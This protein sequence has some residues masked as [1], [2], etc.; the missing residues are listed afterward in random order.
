MLI[1]R[2]QDKQ[3]YQPL[4]YQML[5]ERHMNETEQVVNALKNRFAELQTQS[6]LAPFITLRE[7]DSIVLHIEEM[8]QSAARSLL[9]SGFPPE[10]QQLQGALHQAVRAGRKVFA[11][12]M[13]ESD[14]GLKYQYL[15]HISPMQYRQVE[16]HGRWFALIAVL[17]AGRSGY[18]S[19]KIPTLW[20]SPKMNRHPQVLSKEGNRTGGLLSSAEVVR[21]ALCKGLRAIAITDHD[22][23]AGVRKGIVEGEKLGIEVIPGFELS[24]LYGEREVHVLGYYIRWDDPNLQ[25][26]LERIAEANR[27]WL[28]REVTLPDMGKP[29]N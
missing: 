23:T 5:L 22:T 26:T 27:C 2:E 11:L 14:V 20:L 1:S 10:Y 17:W 19:L 21:L 7:W 6:E 28:I 8:C 3:L 15:H 25:G 9:V 4:P 29:E 24:A 13:G 12:V 16:K 18:R